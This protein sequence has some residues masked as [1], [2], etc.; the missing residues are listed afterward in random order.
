MALIAKDEADHLPRLLSS[1]SG[2]FDQVVLLDTGSSD[3]TVAIFEEW[4]SR[5]TLPL[6]SKV[7]HF[8]WCDD[9]GA[10]RN[11]AHDLL[12]T[13][14]HVRADC[15][16]EIRG[17]HLIKPRVLSFPA[18]VTMI[19]V[20]VRTAGVFCPWERIVRREDARWYGRI[21]EVQWSGGR[22]SQLP[23]GSWSSEPEIAWLESPVSE[24]HQTR[25]GPKFERNKVILR[26]WLED[27]PDH[28]TI[29]GLQATEEL[30]R[31]DAGEA[32]AA[33]LRDYLNLPRVR[34]EFGQRR[35]KEAEKLIPKVIPQ[36][37]N[38]LEN[39]LGV[40]GRLPQFWLLEEEAPGCGPSPLFPIPRV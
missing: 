39:L 34:E 21:H 14:W 8:A 5:Q 24:K 13:D 22:V 11:A 9:F 10:A 2:A 32:A 18:S 35:V 25:S 20:P 38:Y 40:L 27:R 1:I 16:E 23:R 29:V 30:S 26:G 19:R 12:D 37:R 33:Y 7:G 28:P 17:A 6:G 3:A 4:A 15:D 36:R 31:G